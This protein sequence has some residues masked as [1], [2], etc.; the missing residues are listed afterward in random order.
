MK[1]ERKLSRIE[2]NY[3]C[4]FVF[5]HEIKMINFN[6]NY[7]MEIL[8]KYCDR[9]SYMNH[10]ATPAAAA[11][12]ISERC[13]IYSRSFVRFAFIYFFFFLPQGVSPCIYFA[14]FSEGLSAYIDLSLFCFALQCQFVFVI[15]THFYSHLTP[16]NAC[17]CIA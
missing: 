10:E 1:N 7:D 11:N 17:N 6:G 2:P 14:F 12:T 9:C 16:D 15:E 8:C 4:K 13:S 5:G 3:I